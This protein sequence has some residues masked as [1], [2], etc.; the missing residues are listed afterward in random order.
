M[1]QKIFWCFDNFDWISQ[2]YRIT[3]NVIFHYID[4]ME[5]H[6]ITMSRNEITYLY[7]FN[8]SIRTFWLNITISHASGYCDILLK[9][10]DWISQYHI[11]CDIVILA[12]SSYVRI[13]QY[14]NIFFLWWVWL[15]I[16][17]SWYHNITFG[18]SHT[19]AQENDLFLWYLWLNITISQYHIRR[20]F[21]L[22]SPTTS[23]LTPQ[24]KLKNATHRTYQLLFLW[25]IWG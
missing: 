2:Y 23:G 15:N 5:Y 14:H 18:K 25:K 7:C 21:S 13:S 4:L 11:Q 17:I 6:N 20:S 8:Y 16:T 9:P 24:I 19:L 12:H 3:S 22:A 10:F 1:A